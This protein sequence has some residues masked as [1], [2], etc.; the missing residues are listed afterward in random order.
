MSQRLV[1]QAHTLVGRVLRS[2]DLAVDGTAGN[3]LDALFLAECVGP[4]G[5]VL[6]FDVQPGALKTTGDRLKAQR[7]ANFTLVNAC[8][9]LLAD[10]L[11]AGAQL[12]AA[13][14]NLGYLPGGD[15]RITTQPRT[16]ATAISAA[17]DH[18]RPAGI[19]TVIA[20]TGHAGGL[21]EAQAV[22]ELLDAID[23]N[24]FERV[25]DSTQPVRS[26]EPRLF[27]VRRVAA[28]G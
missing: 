8:H 24:R 3:G 12:G 22:Q 11:P 28:S 23:T 26:P 21:Q 6:A 20:Y 15:Q 17:L 10:H 1:E 9:A 16:S 27:A 14:F 18:L 5:Q 25:D 13:M 4:T 7:H 2:G 19:V